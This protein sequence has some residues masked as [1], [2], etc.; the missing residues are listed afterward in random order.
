M[1]AADAPPAPTGYMSQLDALRAFAVLGVV[2]HHFRMEFFGADLGWLAAAGVRLFFVISG[3]LITGILVRSR[4]RAE[5][6]G[7]GRG[8]ALRR[9]YARRFLRIFPL[10]YFVVAVGIVFAVEPARRI[11]VWLLTYTFNLFMA[12]NGWFEANFAHFWSLAVE[13]QFYVVWPWLL[14]L[15]PRKGLFPMALAVTAAAPAWKLV[16][17]L[18]GYT[19]ATGL[20]TFI[21]TFACLDALGIGALLAML[22]HRKSPAAAWEPRLR[23]IVIAAAAVV[24]ALGAADVWSDFTIVLSATAQAVLFAWIVDAASRTTGGAAGAVLACRPLQYVGRISYGVYVYHPFVPAMLVW[25][26]FALPPAHRFEPP[27]L[28]SWGWFA[29][30]TIVSLGLASVSWHAFEKPIN[31]LKRHFEEPPVPARP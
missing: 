12:H 26:G 16:Y 9:F 29:V 23:R 17:V 8:G 4:D 25:F 10:Y 13:E 24:T 15:V 2:L 11:A 18:S 14:F 30:A 5:A 6:T 20:A 31:D 21:S 7:G 28:Q 3:F 19:T 27:L 1:N 22:R